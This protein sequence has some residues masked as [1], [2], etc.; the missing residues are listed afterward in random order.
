MGVQ[1]QGEVP[2]LALLQ[3][4][5]PQGELRKLLQQEQKMFPSKLELFSWDLKS[6]A[7]EELYKG[8]YPAPAAPQCKTCLT[9]GASLLQCEY[10]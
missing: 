2:S 4:Q 9:W 10:L 1:V 6:P 8:L 3:L 5:P 7:H